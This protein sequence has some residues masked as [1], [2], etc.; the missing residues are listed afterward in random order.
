MDMPLGST[1]A[2]APAPTPNDQPGGN[3][4]ARRWVIALVSLAVLASLYMIGT[5]DSAVQEASV[6][7]RSD[8]SYDSPTDNSTP[9]TVPGEQTP[10]SQTVATPTKTVE[11]SGAFKLTSKSASNCSA[12]APADWTMESNAESN[13][14]DLFGPGKRL[15][16]GYGIQAI[17]TG[18]AQF[19]GAYD[20]PL[21]D[22]DLYS[23]DP[24]TVTKAYAKAVVGAIGGSSDV[25]YTDAYNQAI[26]D[27]TLRSVAT[28]THK[29]VI[30]FH[31]NGFPGD[32]I[33][34]SYAEPM[35]FAFTTNDLWDLQGMLVAQV[36][37]TIKCSVQLVQH[38]GPVV[39]A[40]IGGGSSSSDGNG[41]AD[42][43][44]PQ[45]G[46]EYVHDSST[47]ENYLVSPSSNWSSDGPDGA[48]YYKQ[49][50]TDYTKLQPGRA[51]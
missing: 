19:A 43:Y 21:N 50:G 18:L 44:N 38:S 32:N 15:Y 26:G 29:G 3:N 22:P 39:E 49:N 4:P 42:G 10:S 34:Y 51:D 47:G 46:T 20:P 23:E 24:A 17:N 40:Q 7:N 14:A 37:A 11:A 27:Y 48:G 8:T 33:N 13:S 45:L 2:A 41:S 9:T 16:A 25:R 12:Q 1:E 6:D 35:Y 30:F 28:S 31:T 36:A 5:Q